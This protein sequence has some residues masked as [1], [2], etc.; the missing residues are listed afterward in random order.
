MKPTWAVPGLLLT[1][2][3]QTYIEFVSKVELS[4]VALKY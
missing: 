3:N 4:S 2:V 1:K